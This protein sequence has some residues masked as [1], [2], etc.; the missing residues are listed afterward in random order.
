VISASLAAKQFPN[1][2]PIGKVFEY[3]NMDGDLTPITIVG[4]VGDTKEGSLTSAP[5]AAIYLSNRQRQNQNS[6]RY[7]VIA[8]SNEA[9]TIGGARG[10]LRETVPGVAVRFQTIEEIIARSVSTQ[11][12]MLILVGVFGLTALLLATLGVYSVISYLVAQRGKEIS[13][14]VALGAR[15]TDIVQL[16]VR[17]GVALAVGGAALGAVAAVLVTRLLTTMLF[18]ISATDPIAFVSVIGLLCVVAVVASYLPARRAAN[19][20]PMDVLRAG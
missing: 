19:A 16:V 2:S 5:D 8:T 10:V 12:F 20:A 11:R 13:I 9:S 14:R 18:E 7:F 15:G 17:Q 6:D 3:G 1:E 4:V